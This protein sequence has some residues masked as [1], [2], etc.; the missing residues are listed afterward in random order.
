MKIALLAYQH[1]NEPLGEL[2]YS[3]IQASH[4]DVLPHVELIIGNPR[5]KERD[6]RYIESDMNRSYD[7]AL[8]T[9]ESQRAREVKSHIAK[10]NYDLVL[11]LHTTVCIQ[12]PCI[13]VSQLTDTN[14]RFMQAS[15][16][17]RVVA[18]RHPIVQS[19]LIGTLPDVLSIECANDSITTEVLDQLVADIRRF[20]NTKTQQTIARYYQIDQLIQKSAISPEDAAR[21]R[22]F[23]MSD[24]GF[25]PIL[26]GENSY[27]KNTDYLGFKADKETII[28]L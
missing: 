24:L 12:P 8:N 5:A 22:N 17:D 21:L 1:G 19:S 26:V 28:T 6:V 2:L 3:R 27:K 15:T 16:I 4:P 25:I 11:D 7:P 10:G 13:I 23:E 20:I 14:R 9:Y 18:I